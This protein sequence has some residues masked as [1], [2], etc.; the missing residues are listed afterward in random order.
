MY[1]VASLMNNQI[2]FPSFVPNRRN[3]SEKKFTEFDNKIS[4]VRF[5]RPEIAVVLMFAVVVACLFV[6]FFAE[7]PFFH[8]VLL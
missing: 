3:D 8:V 7:M 4:M 2:V 1:S 5:K 6:E